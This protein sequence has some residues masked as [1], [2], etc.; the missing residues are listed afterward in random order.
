MHSA[1]PVWIESSRRQ[2]AKNH[3]LTTEIGC[4][5]AARELRIE[6]A[7][8]G[9]RRGLALAALAR[10]FDRLG[11]AIE[12]DSSALRVQAGRELGQAY[13]IARAA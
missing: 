7:R 2:I 8:V 10:A 11:S 3:D 12:Q 6:G 4:R 13:E 1:C 5:Q 9:G